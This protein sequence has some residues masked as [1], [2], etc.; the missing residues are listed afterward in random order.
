MEYYFVK[1]FSSLKYGQN[2]C[3]QIPNPLSFY[4]KGSHL[5]DFLKNT[6]VKNRSDLL[7]YFS[8]G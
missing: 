3:H 5:L 2:N 6:Q 1:F 7:Q 4:K 8:F